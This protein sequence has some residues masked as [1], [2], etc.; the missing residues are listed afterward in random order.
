MPR[1]AEALPV[2]TTGR[3]ST[4]PSLRLKAAMAGPSRDIGEGDGYRGA[5]LAGHAT[6][7]RE[8]GF[9]PTAAAERKGR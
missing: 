7:L 2:T 5:G 3:D 4:M 1:G 9:Q 6:E 8:D